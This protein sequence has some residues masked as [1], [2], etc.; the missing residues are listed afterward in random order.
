MNAKALYRNVEQS[1]Q[2][3][4]IAIAFLV[5][6]GQ[7][8]I[9][10]HTDRHGHDAVLAAL[11]NW[12]AVVASGDTERLDTLL[13]PEFQI[14]RAD[15]IG[16][17]REAYLASE[18]PQITSVP[19]IDDLVVMIND[20]VAVARYVL[21]IDETIAGTAVRPIAPRMT[22]LRRDGDRWLIVAHANFG[23]PVN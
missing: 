11:N 19:V 18:L 2:T 3:W 15:G 5:S 1:L 12:I 21:T 20:D 17:D 6:A 7:S 9:A 4:F 8:A 23:N 16:Y 10:Q 13:A 14:Q 22:I